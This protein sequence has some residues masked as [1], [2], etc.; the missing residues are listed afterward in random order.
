[1]HVNKIFDGHNYS[2]EKKVR[3]TSME[4]TEYALVWWD[5]KNRTRERPATWVEMKHVMREMFVPA[6][7]TRQFHSKLCHVMQGTKSL[8][9]MLPY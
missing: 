8:M 3:V 5:N 2:E 7:Y 4:F 6:C 9:H 1:M